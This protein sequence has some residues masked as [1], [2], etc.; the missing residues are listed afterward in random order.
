[1]TV[2]VAQPPEKN[3]TDTNQGPRLSALSLLLAICDPRCC[4]IRQK[5]RETT[6]VKAASPL[7]PP[8]S[9]LNSSLGSHL[10][11]QMVVVQKGGE[12]H[13]LQC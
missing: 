13:H 7:A 10:E 12:M 6:P 2:D 11:E 3:T 9:N 8:L 5:Q 1:M 4:R